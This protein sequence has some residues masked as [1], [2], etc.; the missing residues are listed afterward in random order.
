MT[1]SGRKLYSEERHNLYY[2]PDIREIKSKEDEMG[3]AHS[4]QVMKNTYKLLVRKPE[5]K[6]PP[7]RHRYRWKDTEMDLKETGCEP[8]SFCTG[9]GPE[10]GSCDYDNKPSGSIKGVEF[11]NWLS[12]DWHL[13]DSAPWNFL[14]M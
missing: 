1:Q 5:G 14:C 3:E 7:G 12:D 8:D 10:T 11:L 6:R 9:Q 4:M 13:K 2:S